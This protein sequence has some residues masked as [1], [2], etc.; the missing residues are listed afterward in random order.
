ML[1]PTTCLV[2]RE[3]EHDCYALVTRYFDATS[4]LVALANTGGS[5][6][7]WA[8]HSACRRLLADLDNA[9]DQLAAHQA[10]HRC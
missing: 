5:A 4:S 3:L 2:R 1:K 9:K 6:V 8:T 7:Y 10:M